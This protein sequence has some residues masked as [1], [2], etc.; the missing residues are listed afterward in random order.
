MG[1]ALSAAEKS[2]NKTKY[3]KSCPMAYKNNNPSEL[4]Q[5]VAVLKQRVAELESDQVKHKQTESE[6][7]Q[8]REMLQLIFDTIPARVFWKRNDLTYQGCNKSFAQ[9]AGLDS[10]D[11][12]IGKNDFDLGWKDFAKQYQEDDKSVIKSGTPKLNF[13]E[14]LVRGDGEK[15]W[16]KT[17]KVPLCNDKGEV[18]GIL[19][20][21]EDITE[22]KLAY[23]KLQ[24]ERILLKTLVDNLPD[25]IYV[26]DKEGHK[27]LANIA[28][29]KNAGF[30]TEAD[31]LGK[32]DFELF[33]K[34]VAEK[35]WADDQLVMNSGEAVLSREEYLIKPDG[36]KK[37]LL[38]SKLPLRDHK[39][40]ITGLIGIGRDIT[41]HKLAEETL[42]ESAEKFKLIFE[43]A[44]DGFSIFEE[45]YE[46]GKRRLIE[47][48][49]RYAE[50]AGRSREELLKIGNIEEAGLTKNISE[51]NSKYIEQG[52]KFKGIFSWERPDQKENIIEYAAVPIKMQG[53]TYTFGVDRDITEK[54]KSEEAIQQERILLRTLIDNLPD[55]IYVKDK[56]SRKSIANLTDVK[57]MGKQS[58]ADV[59]GKT[60]FEFFP[61]EEAEK[62]F[63]DDQSVITTGKPVVNREE[64]FSDPQGNKRWLL[65]SKLPL[66]DVDKNIVGLIGIGH[67]ITTR[68]KAEEK[69]KRAYDELEKVNNDLINAN[70]VKGQF[71][72]N[73]SHEIRTPLNAVI[74]MTGLLLDTELD[75]DQREFAET[76]YSSG[77]I[78]LSLINDILDYSKIEAKKLEIEKQPFDV[79][80][81]IEEALDLVTSKAA[82]KKLELVYSIEDILSTN[83]MGDVTRLRQILLNLLSNAIKFT[84]KGEIEVAV[85]GQLR[86]H[87][88]YQLHFSV[89]DTG[90]GIPAEMR[91][92]LFQSFTQVDASTTR[93]FGGTGLGLAISKQLCELMGGTIWIESSGIPGEGSTFHFTIDT[94]LCVE[95]QAPDDFS[96]LVGK[97]ILIVDDNKTN[98]NIL[99]RQT[100][101]L[102]MIPTTAASGFEALEI[103]EQC[104]RF[105]LAV[106]DFH[107]P[108]MDGLM[109]SE[110][111]R[112]LHL[113]QTLPLILLSSFGYREKKVGLSEFAATLTKPVKLSHLH[114]ALITVLKGKINKSAKTNQL[115]AKYNVEIAEQYPLRIL[116]AEDNKVNQKVALRYLEKI[117]YK[118]GIAFNGLEVLEALKHQVFDVILMDV[119]MPEMDGEQCTIEIRKMGSKIFQPRIVAVTANAMSSDKE[120]YLSI[121]MDDYVVKPFKVDE[122]VRALIESYIFLKQAEELIEDEKKAGTYS[123]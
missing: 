56:F 35:F 69:L 54:V 15:R 74:G 88:E 64:S 82:D 60:D 33:P 39:N 77:D 13:E 85:S 116:L 122:L 37:W 107:M 115:P 47:C 72:A 102:K 73:M 76:I 109:L 67:D 97:R 55:A 27:T 38:T 83:V 106:L 108:G 1:K 117:G 66:R 58:E 99:E 81:C 5:E 45:N 62:F 43:N 57:N 118:A 36:K 112:K 70:K 48:N 4:L 8:S 79:R 90:L 21:Y 86:D 101:S 98:R 6:L 87:Y 40:N 30:N 41:E 14:P 23:E 42:R 17:S 12:I 78:L 111:I 95:K 24:H 94:E 52:I 26:K 71:L 29:V 9:D 16:L 7:N 100:K 65:T 121:G 10:T 119:Q 59:L 31:V 68:K 92:K 120:K 110:K 123:V 22:I 46:P 11:A 50:L 91:N 63:K 80:T 18:I 3:R 93:K 75:S 44:F 49:E 32:T 28:N 89:R 103:L 51:N 2:K 104:K 34:E 105:D 25:S 53:V 96:A 20:T 61:K 84:E 19:G 113:K 114:D